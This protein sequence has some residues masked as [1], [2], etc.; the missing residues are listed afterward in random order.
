MS[1]G[2]RRGL[3]RIAPLLQVNQDVDSVKRALAN[4]SQPWLLIFDN[5]DDPHLSLTSFFPSGD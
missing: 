1:D 2:I 4:T 5:A 3:L